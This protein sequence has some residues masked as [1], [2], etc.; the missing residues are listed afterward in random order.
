MK[1]LLK[2][3]YFLF[4]LMYFQTGIAVETEIDEAYIESL[5]SIPRPSRLIFMGGTVERDAEGYIQVPLYPAIS[6]AFLNDVF[7]TRNQTVEILDV[8]AGDSSALRAVMENPRA[9]N[10]PIRYTVVETQES[11]INSMKAFFQERTRGDATKWFG[12]SHKDFL[13]FCKTN[14]D[15]KRNKYDIVYAGF[16]LHILEPVKYVMALNSIQSMLKPG[17]KLYL[18]QHS[19]S[20]NGYKDNYLKAL[21]DKLVMPFWEDVGTIGFSSDVRTMNRVAQDFGFTVVKSELAA[22]LDSKM[23]CTKYLAMI[24]EKPLDGG[25]RSKINDYMRVAKMYLPMAQ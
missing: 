25:Q 6:D 10:F 13:D 15:Q 2:T 3:A 24:L 9:R 23:T 17:G 12:S 20:G 8:F 5:R 22:F 1:S 18:T 4:S 19:F 16:A 21:E 14:P 11:H 7:A